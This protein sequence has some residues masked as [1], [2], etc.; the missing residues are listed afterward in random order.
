MNTN[1][2]NEAFLERFGMMFEQNY[3]DAG[4]EEKILRKEFNFMGIKDEPVDYV[5]DL[6][7]WAA[8]TRNSFDSGA[9]EDLITTRRLV[10]IVRAYAVLGGN[11]D[12]AIERCVSRFDTQVKDSFMQLWDKVKSDRTPVVAV[13]DP[14]DPNS[15]M[16]VNTT[17]H[18]DPVTGVITF[19]VNTDGTLKI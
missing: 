7:K 10:H 11:E 8:I 19:T 4:V 17:R 6:V 3:P 15:V 14:Q 5:R 12:L 9:V 18:V 1:I 16:S 13:A 2:M